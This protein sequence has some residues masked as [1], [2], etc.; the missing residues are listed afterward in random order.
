MSSQ[1]ISIFPCL[2][3]RLSNVVLSVFLKI[4]LWI[5]LGCKF[6]VFLYLEIAFFQL[7]RV[8]DVSGIFLGCFAY[9]AEFFYPFIG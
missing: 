9:G 8:C 4:T 6:N 2:S 1:F 5:L 7:V 3:F